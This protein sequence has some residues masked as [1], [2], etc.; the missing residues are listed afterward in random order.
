MSVFAKMRDTAKRLVAK[1]GD[2]G[3]LLVTRTAG[4]F[5]PVLGKYEGGAT[6]TTPLTATILPI[7]RGTSLSETF[8]RGRVV[9]NMRKLITV[10][11]IEVGDVL[12]FQGDEWNVADANRIDPDSTGNIVTV[13]YVEKN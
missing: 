8:M 2:N 5:N 12:R 1:T 13:A 11:P 3:V 4:T 9:A 6:T 10:E 7:D